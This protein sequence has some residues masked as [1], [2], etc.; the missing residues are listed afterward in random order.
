MSAGLAVGAKA[1]RS[2]RIKQLASLKTHVKLNGPLP[3]PTNEQPDTPHRLPNPFLPHKN[4]LTGRWAPP[5]ISLRRQADLVKKAKA[6]NG[7]YLLPPGPKCPKPSDLTAQAAAKLAKDQ[8][9]GT[10]GKGLVEGQSKEKWRSSLEGTWM[11]PVDWVGEPKIKEVPGAEL[12]TRLYAGKKRMFKGH[13]WERLKAGRDKKKKVLMRDMA[14]RIRNYKSLPKYFTHACPSL[15]LS[16]EEAEPTQGLQFQQVAETSLLRPDVDAQWVHDKA[17]T[18]PRAAAGRPRAS[19][20][21][22]ITESAN[23]KLLV[24]NLH[25]EITPKDLTGTASPELHLKKAN[26]DLIAY[27]HSIFA[28]ILKYDRSGRSSGTA[29]ISF[30]TTAEATRAKKQ[31]DGI[32]AKGINISFATFVVPD[33]CSALYTLLIT[34]T[35]QPMTITFDTAP[36][37]K[38]RRSASAP[39]SLIN[40]IQKPPLLDRLSKDD[41]GIKT[42]TPTGPRGNVGP[43]RTRAP[44]APRAPKKPKT[45]EE[46]DKELDAFMGDSEAV[47]AEKPAA[48]EAAA[49]V[50]DVEMS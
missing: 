46:L 33:V 38:T 8:F 35:G 18:G 25:Y 14:R 42:K 21:P 30:E 32:L 50:Q 29:I 1:V 27:S 34:F 31:F 5:T 47:A 7:L 39:T 43:V 12:G 41:A 2:F 6:S 13:R 20:V 36:A 9:G 26:L 44:R 4:P 48:D 10:I 40:R 19:E 3:P 37:P 22:Q 17:P 45:A 11:N 16:E 15:V 49:T 24:S 28:S 23:T